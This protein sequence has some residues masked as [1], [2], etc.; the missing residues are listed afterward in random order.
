MSVCR[1]IDD[2]DYYVVGGGTCF[3][4]DILTLRDRGSIDFGSKA[5]LIK[6]SYHSAGF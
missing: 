2:Y 5:S 4:K 3:A 6:I 1:D